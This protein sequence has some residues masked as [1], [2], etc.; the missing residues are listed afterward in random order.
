MGVVGESVTENNTVENIEALLKTA[1]ETVIQVFISPHYYF[2]HDH[3]WKFEGALEALM[4]DVGMFDR[5]GPLNVE[6][7][8]GTGLFSPGDGPQPCRTIVSNPL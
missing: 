4:H 3:G 2:P 7:F 5:T 1:K 8:E 6:G